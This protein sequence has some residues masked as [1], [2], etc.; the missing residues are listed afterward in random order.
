MEIVGR[1]IRYVKHFEMNVVDE[2]NSVFQIY[3]IYYQHANSV[4]FIDLIE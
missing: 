4:V 3:S 2:R 1:E